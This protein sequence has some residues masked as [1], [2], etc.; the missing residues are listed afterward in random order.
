MPSYMDLTAYTV[1]APSVSKVRAAS[2]AKDQTLQPVT[3]SAHSLPVDY[4]RSA[5]AS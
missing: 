1:H 3:E 5:K 4:C 2:W